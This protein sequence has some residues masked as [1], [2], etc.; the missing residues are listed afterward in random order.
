MNVLYTSEKMQSI[1]K[2]ESCKID[3]SWLLEAEY[4]DKFLEY[5]DQP[6]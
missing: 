2:A 5:F 3:F 1:I 4:Y 6:P